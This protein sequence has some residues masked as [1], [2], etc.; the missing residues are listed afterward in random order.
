MSFVKTAA[1]LEEWFR[2]AGRSNKTLG[3]V[4]TM[5]YLHEGH[6]SLI[7]AAK[8]END[9]VAVS[10]FVNPTQFAP[11][12][13]FES[14][15]RDEA[16]DYQLA[17]EAGANVVF[18]PDGSEI[19][20]PGAS[21]QVLVIGEITKKLCG[22]SRPTHF[23]GVTQVVSILFNIV[24]PNRAYFGQKDAQQ[25]LII[26]KMVRDLH[27]PVEIRVCPII[28]EAD[29]LAMSSRNVYLTPEERNQAVCLNQALEKAEQYL[30][31]DAPDCSNIKKLTSIIKEEIE[32][33]CLGRIDYCDIFDGE[34]LEDITEIL[35][36][37]KA[38]AAV[39]VKFSKAR[40]LDNR[41][42]SL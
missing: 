1:A 40:L 37:K 5:G 6:L 39:A 24:R 26:K 15:P 9:L 20:L 35:P 10:I 12:E 28:R 8:K 27:I 22:I 29:G 41:I 23:G 31:S 19:Y 38:L 18:V 17:I 33:H 7:K 21:T 36:G 34:T 14:Y 42:W 16:R 30:Y 13:D 3:F 11:G 25:A 32:S 4:P 2:E